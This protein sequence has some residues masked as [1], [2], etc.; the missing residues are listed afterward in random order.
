ALPLACGAHICL[1]PVPDAP[2]LRSLPYGA[3]ADRLVLLWDRYPNGNLTMATPL[4]ADDWTE[5]N[6]T[7]DA[8]AAFS[9]GLV[10]V[11]GPDGT[12]EQVGLQAVTARFFDVLGV[13]PIAGRTFVPA[14]SAPDVVVISEGF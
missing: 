11:T 9:A 4:D 1:F 12:P 5:Q 10:T 14:D 13:T 7:F 2:V 6:T 3:P 8:M